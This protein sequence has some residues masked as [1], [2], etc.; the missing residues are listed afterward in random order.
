M[1]IEAVKWPRRSGSGDRGLL[2]YNGKI[3]AT[4]GRIYGFFGNDRPARAGDP[5]GALR[6]GFY[7]FDAGGQ[8]FGADG[9]AVAVTA[10]LAEGTD[11]TKFRPGQVLKIVGKATTPDDAP[12]SLSLANAVVLSVSGEG[13]PAF[14]PMQL[15]AAVDK[16]TKT[17]AGGF[18]TDRSVTLTGVVSAVPKASEGANPVLVVTEGTAS[19]RVQVTNR[20]AFASNPPKPGETVT[21]IGNVN[22]FQAGNTPLNFRGLLLPR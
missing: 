20:D 7:L 2:T 10:Y 15:D 21:L 11:W 3:I 16:D 22:N 18:T 12:T 6:V 19:F 8:I 9:K 5:G 13:D 1:T 17:Y 14:T 4:E